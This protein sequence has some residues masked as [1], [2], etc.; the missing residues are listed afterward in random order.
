MKIST[1][2]KIS[3]LFFIFSAFYLYTA[4]QIRVFS[5]DENAAFNAKTFPIYLGYFGMFIAALK[6]VLPEKASEEVDQKFLN[7]KK[8]LI[9]VLIMVAYGLII[10]PVGFFLSTSLFLLSSY[11]FL[12]ERRWLRMF[13]LSF[14]FV[15]IFM[16]LIHGLL[17]IYLTDP[18]LKSLGVIG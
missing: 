9:L 2:K 3:L 18:I 1:V 8:T 12:G 7:Y 15:A 6:I 4:Y 14:P 17:D 10:R 5:F 16:F 11:Y 13:M